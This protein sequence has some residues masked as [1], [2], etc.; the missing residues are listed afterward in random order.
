MEYH[1]TG[2]LRIWVNETITAPNEEVA[3]ER[4]KRKYADEVSDLDVDANA[5]DIDISN[6]C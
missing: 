4:L 5:L 3:L 2:F 6:N 1:I